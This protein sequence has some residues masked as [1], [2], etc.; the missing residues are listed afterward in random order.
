MLSLSLH[1]YVILLPGTL[2]LSNDV[3]LLDA[4]T[5][6]N[7]VIVVPMSTSIYRFLACFLSRRHHYLPTLK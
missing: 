1:Q 3:L 2:T 7:D 5:S 4:L 6:T